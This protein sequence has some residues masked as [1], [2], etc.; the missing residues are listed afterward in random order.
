MEFSSFWRWVTAQTLRGLLLLV[1]LLV[2]V[3]FVVWI[4]GYI[5][6]MLRPLILLVWPG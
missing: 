3:K 6:R 2:T 4:S 1:P 5:E